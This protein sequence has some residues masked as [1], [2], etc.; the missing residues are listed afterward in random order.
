MITYSFSKDEERF[1]GT[2]DSAERAAAEA[3]EEDPD[4][5]HVWVGRNVTP[6]R[7]IDEED[8]IENV[9]E[10]TTEESGDWS[11]GYLFR[12]PKDVREDL[13]VRLQNAWDEWEKI[14]NLAP[15]WWNVEDIQLIL[16][17]ATPNQQPA[18]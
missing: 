3:F 11:E 15:T 12:L 6:P 18:T 1:E 7:R 17:P 5:D 2:F 8:V 4:C 14:H 13:R 16:R 10:S 9:A